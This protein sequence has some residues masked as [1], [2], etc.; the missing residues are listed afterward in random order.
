MN[1]ANSCPIQF[2]SFFQANQ[3]G[4][5]KYDGSPKPNTTKF[6]NFK[7]TEKD[8]PKKQQGLFFMV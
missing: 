4:L 7:G 5:M 8:I 1:F 3:C 6:A 2:P